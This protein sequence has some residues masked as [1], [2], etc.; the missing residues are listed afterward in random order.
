MCVICPAICFH[1]SQRI[2]STLGGIIILV[3]TLGMGY[4]VCVCWVHTT[5]HHKLHGI[6]T[7]RVHAPRACV[8]AREC[9]RSLIFGWIISIFGKVI[10]RVNI[11]CMSNV[12]VMSTRC[13][14]TSWGLHASQSDKHFF[15]NHVRDVYHLILIRVSLV[16]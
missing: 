8:Q 6:C 7:F 16:I 3:M 13:V 2:L 12:I 9:E 14:A 11:N 15:E 10:L 4:I 1:S 5:N